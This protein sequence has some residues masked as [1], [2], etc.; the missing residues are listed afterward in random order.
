MSAMSLLVLANIQMQKYIYFTPKEFIVIS[1]TAYHPYICD[2]S[3]SMFTHNIY[4]EI[5]DTKV[6]Y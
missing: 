2:D 4:N 1:E 3:N 5:K 6:Y